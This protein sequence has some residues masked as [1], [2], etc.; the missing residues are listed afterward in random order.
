M[1]VGKG[2]GIALFCDDS[3]DVKLLSYGSR[4]IDVHIR[5][6]PHGPGWRGTFVSGEPKSHERHHMWILLKRIKRNSAEL[7]M[8]IGD[9]NKTMWQG[10]HFSAAKRS[11]TYNREFQKVSI[12]V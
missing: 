11:E 12:L 3:V 2:A 4:Y 8:M 7:W 10:L 9:F 6:D 5:D 1:G